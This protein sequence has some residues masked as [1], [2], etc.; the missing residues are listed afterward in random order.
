MARLCKTKIWWKNKIVYIKTGDI[1]KDIAED[2]EFRFDAWNCKLDRP[3]Q[4]RNNKNVIGLMR[5]EL[6]GKIMPNLLYYEHKL[7]VT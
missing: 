3:I 6:E 1:Y 2:A 7:I 4:K 5:S